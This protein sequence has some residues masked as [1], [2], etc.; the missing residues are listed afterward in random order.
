MFPNHQFKDS[1]LEKVQISNNNLT[2]FIHSQIKK[3]K[4][5]FAIY[6]LPDDVLKVLLKES[7]IKQDEP[8]TIV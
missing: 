1:T 5:R 4:R 8:H 3:M 6:E 2:N 7:L